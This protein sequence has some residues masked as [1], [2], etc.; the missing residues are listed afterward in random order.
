MADI[1][2]KYG[3]KIYANITN[4]CNCRCTFCIRFLHE[5]LGDAET[6]WHKTE[7]SLEEVLE[8]IRTY[9][10]GGCKELVFCGYGEP[11]CALDVLLAAAKCAKEERGLHL[12]LNTNGLGSLQNG[13]DIVPELA[14]YIDEVSISLNAPTKEDYEKVTRPQIE[15]A[16]EAMKEFAVSCKGKMDVMWTVVDVLPEEQIEA[17]RRLSEE[18][19]IRL[20]VRHYT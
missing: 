6:L 12:R 3:D 11:T 5:G 7:P 10:F 14:Q 1:L 13:R 9:D 18:T 20:R 2:Y 4:K 17:S 16:Y 8:A 19:G 15:N